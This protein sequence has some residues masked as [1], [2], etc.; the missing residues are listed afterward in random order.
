MIAESEC[1]PPPCLYAEFSA[2]FSRV[3]TTSPSSWVRLEPDEFVERLFRECAT[4]LSRLDALDPGFQR[5]IVVVFH[6]KWQEPA[7]SPPKT[8]AA[9]VFLED[10][11]VK[12]KRQLYGE[13]AARSAFDPRKK[14]VHMKA[15]NRSTLFLQGMLSRVERQLRKPHF[16]QDCGA[17]GDRLVLLS[18]RSNGRICLSCVMR[19]GPMWDHYRSLLAAAP[20]GRWSGL[21]RE[22]TYLLQAP[23]ASTKELVSRRSHGCRRNE[24]LALCFQVLANP[25]VGGLWMSEKTIVRQIPTNGGASGV[26]PWAIR[27]ELALHALNHP[28]R[29][30]YVS[31]RLGRFLFEFRRPDQYR[32]LDETI[33]DREIQALGTNAKSVRTDDLRG[34]YELQSNGKFVAHNTPGGPLS[35]DG[36]E[37]LER[38]V[39]SKLSIGI[40]EV[41]PPEIYWVVEQGRFQSTV[42]IGHIV[43]RNNGRIGIED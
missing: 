25:D 20:S 30:K 10:C 2:A 37:E 31:R 32:V 4:F 1:P 17:F 34:R 15:F 21:E 42:L 27:R 19:Y 11:M 40:V 12:L 6:P 36:L 3:I 33:S 26:T 28:D 18:H 14:G 5:A 23:E 7:G 13:D 41:K 43:R 38:F 29:T 24:V 39:K 8:P 35:V 9:Q 22:T 16:C